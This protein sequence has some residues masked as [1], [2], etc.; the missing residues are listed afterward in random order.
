MAKVG[1]YM[2]K[3]ARKR[4]N[5]AETIRAMKPGEQIELTDDRQRIQALQLSKNLFDAKVITFKLHTQRKGTRFSATAIA[6]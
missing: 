5:L 6:Q 3:R 2:S 1:T 4:D